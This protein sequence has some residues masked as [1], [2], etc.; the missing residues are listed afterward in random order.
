MGSVGDSSQKFVNTQTITEVVSFP[1]SRVRIPLPRGFDPT[2]TPCTLG[3]KTSIAVI[4]DLMSYEVMVSPAL[5]MARGVGRGANREAR[6]L[7]GY[8]G[9]KAGGPTT[10]WLLLELVDAPQLGTY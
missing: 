1:R 3:S 4:Q 8:R 2:V 9:W 6:R 5:A 10:G 7:H